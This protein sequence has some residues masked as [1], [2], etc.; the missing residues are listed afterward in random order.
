[1]YKEN[2]LPGSAG[3]TFFDDT[4]MALHAGLRAAGQARRHS[5]EDIRK[6]CAAGGYTD[7]RLQVR[8]AGIL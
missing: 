6:R 4:G 2:V 5:F 8:R 1:M 7:Q 3:G